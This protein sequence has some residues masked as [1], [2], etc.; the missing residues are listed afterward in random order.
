MTKPI[1]FIMGVSGSG[2]STIGQLLAEKL[3]L[4][5]YDGD[6]FHPPENV[7]KMAK[8]LPLDDDDRHGWLLRLNEL[9]KKNKSTGAIIACSA[10]KHAYRKQLRAGIEDQIEFIFLKGSFDLVAERLNRRKGHFMPPELLK[11]QFEALE[12][13]TSAKVVSID[14]SPEEIVEN[15]I[16]QLN[17]T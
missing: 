16:N 2:K 4:K 8:G 7:T 1:L 12:I 9:A 17:I 6:D 11:S 5:F 3:N 13:P 15:I 14:N 10:L